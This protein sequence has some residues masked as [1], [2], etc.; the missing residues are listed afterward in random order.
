MNRKQ[1][2][3]LTGY[4]K[5]QSQL[6]FLYWQKLPLNF[7]FQ[8]KIMSGLQQSFSLADALEAGIGAGMSVGSAAYLGHMSKS[9]SLMQ[10]ISRQVLTFGAVAVGEQLSEMALGLRSRLDMGAIAGSIAV[11][12]VNLHLGNGL[13]QPVRGSFTSYMENSLA[14]SMIDMEIESTFTFTPPNLEYLAGQAI[15]TSVGMEVGEHLGVVIDHE[16][17]DA[18]QANNDRA[19]SNNTAPSPAPQSIQQAQQQTRDFFARLSASDT[20]DIADEKLPSV[21]IDPNDPDVIE[22]STDDL[23]SASAAS[24]ASA[25][26]LAFGSGGLALAQTATSAVSAATNRNSFFNSSS[27]RSTLPTLPIASDSKDP[28]VAMGVVAPSASPTLTPIANSNPPSIWNRIASNLN[29]VGE[30]AMD[31]I[32]ENIA[33]VNINTLEKAGDFARE[34]L[35]PESQSLYQSSWN[36]AVTAAANTQSPSSYRGSFTFW[37]EQTTIATDNFNAAA[38]YGART[39]G[40]GVIGTLGKMAPAIG[41]GVASYEVSQA[42]PTERNWVAVREYG[43]VVASGFGAAVGTALASPSELVLPVVSTPAVVASSLVGAAAAAGFWRGTVDLIH[44]GVTELEQINWNYKNG[45]SY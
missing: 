3:F 6:F 27:G 43:A 26:Q 22:I 44:E 32:S 19:Q 25:G 31:G 40:W 36:T 12:M 2:L 20:T 13:G 11:S 45:P 16:H 8:Q 4:Q 35:L 37:N 7:L 33:E 14:T 10:Q 23:A 17:D 21:T 18:A 41:F 9:L 38:Q 1:H 15:G 29:R 42:S 34:Q 28:L 30:A 24:S 5:I 39:A